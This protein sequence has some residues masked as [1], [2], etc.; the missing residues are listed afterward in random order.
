MLRPSPLV[1]NVTFAGCLIWAVAVAGAATLTWTGTIDAIASERD[2]GKAFCA[3]RYPDPA[4]KAR[5][6]DL[7]DVQYLSARNSA[8][9]TRVII[10]AL[11]LA[12]FGIW[13]GL[14]RRKTRP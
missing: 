12:G 7:F 14:T 5:C 1:L 9:A 2:S 3:R 8:I 11:P 6:E 10:A 4:A 13:M